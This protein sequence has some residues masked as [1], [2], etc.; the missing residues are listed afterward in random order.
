MAEILAPGAAAANSSTFALTA[1]QSAT[2][3]LFTADGTLP[4]LQAAI[5]HIQKQASNAQWVNTGAFLTEWEPVVVLTGVGTFR[6]A[7]PL[8]AGESVGVDKD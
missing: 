8:L 7:R 1:G 6:V 5:F 3:A 2:L 4:P